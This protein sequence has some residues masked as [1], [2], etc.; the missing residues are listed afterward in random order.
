[1]LV[2]GIFGKPIASTEGNYIVEGL[3][4]R[5]KYYIDENIIKD[6][7]KFGRPTYR[8]DRNYIREGMYKRPNYYID[9]DLIREKNQFGRVVDRM[10][11]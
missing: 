5:P 2:E 4:R 7:N 6:N 9:G 8:I 3:S 11:K 1:M 10:R